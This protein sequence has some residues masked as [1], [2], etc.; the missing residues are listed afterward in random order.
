V[1][2]EKDKVILQKYKEKRKKRIYRNRGWYTSKK[3]I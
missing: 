3:W 1:Q 2:Q